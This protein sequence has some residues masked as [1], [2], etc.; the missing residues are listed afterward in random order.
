LKWLLNERAAQ[1]GDIAKISRN[2]P[3]LQERVHTLESQLRIAQARLQQAQQLQDTA[4]RQVEALDTA[5]LLAHPTVDPSTV[6]PVQAWA[7]KYGARGNLKRYIQVLLQNAAPEPLTTVEI[8]E[9]TSLRFGVPMHT[10]QLR[11]QFLDTIR[12]S[13]RTMRDREG[14]VLYVRGTASGLW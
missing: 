1:L 11:K 6:A 14:L 12:D 3:D 8:L 5:I 10:A 4:A 9:A 7:G 13:L 2:I